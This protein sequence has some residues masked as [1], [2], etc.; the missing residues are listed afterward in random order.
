MF[1]IVLL[2]GVVS[3]SAASE[4]GCQSCIHATEAL[5]KQT[6]I[7]SRSNTRAGDK[8]LALGD[9]LP[10][11]CS[12]YVFSGLER[13][14]ELADACKSEGL[15]K[16]GGV[17]EAALLQGKGVTEACTS[18][19]EGISEAERVPKVKS[20]APAAGKSDPPKGG[21]APRKGS[22][23]DPAYKEALKKKK[24]RDAARAK[25]NAKDARGKL[26]FEEGE[27]L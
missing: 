14:S 4:L 11:M 24:A 9:N 25:R 2:G 20:A 18:F 15:S 1:A 27:E 7:L 13:S 3:A 6:P 8:E 5:I 17:L 19:C 22:V 10:N 26:K 21:K 12:G 23:D 16:S